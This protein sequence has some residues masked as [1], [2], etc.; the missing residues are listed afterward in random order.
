[1]VL[2]LISIHIFAKRGLGSFAENNVFRIQDKFAYKTE[3]RANLLRKAFKFARCVTCGYPS[4]F[5]NV[6]LTILVS[7]TLKCIMKLAVCLFHS[8]ALTDRYN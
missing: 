6:H 2:F 4:C 8:L 5:E 3:M 1:M 7:S